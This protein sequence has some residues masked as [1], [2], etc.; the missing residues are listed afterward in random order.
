MVSQEATLIG[1]ETRWTNGF[2]SKSSQQSGDRVER[3]QVRYEHAGSRG[4][5]VTNL[6]YL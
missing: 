4:V 6:G 3:Q 2:Q 1:P 5:A